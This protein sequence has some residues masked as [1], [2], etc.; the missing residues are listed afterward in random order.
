MRT[1]IT[2]INGFIGSA[3]AAHAITSGHDVVGLIRDINHK[4]KPQS[5]TIIKGDITDIELLKRIIADYEI[6]TIFHL[7]AQSIVKIAHTNP[8]NTFASNINGTINVI[9]A[10][11]Q[12]NKK[13]KIVIA[14]SDKAYG[15]HDTLPYVETMDVRPDGPYATSKACADLIAQS[16]AKEYGMDINIVRCANVYGGGDMNMSRIIP[17]TITRIL[18]GLKPV[19]YSG[20][21]QFKREFIH[22][23]DVCR[24]YLTIAERG[25]P[26]EIYNVGDEQVYTIDEILQKIYTL[27]DYKGDVT[28]VNRHF[29]EI[30]YQ[31]L[32]ATKL[33]GLGWRP[34]VDITIGLSKSI[35]YYA[36]G[37][38]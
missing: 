32:S 20:V 25:Q 29:T 34:Q 7:A 18:K 13:C 36:G 17:N 26:G 10:A 31:Y 4:S 16:Y 38:L 33:K 6:T 37:N 12:V 15:V 2:G 30:P 11:R 24:A 1:L 14:S 28:V 23:D 5:A 9:E 8:V 35:E 27:T 3:L 21:L 22:V 19:V